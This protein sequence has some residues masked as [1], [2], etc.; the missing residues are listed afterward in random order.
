V[1]MLTAHM[2]SFEREKKLCT[3]ARVHTPLLSVFV[4]LWEPID[5]GSRMKRMVQNTW[6]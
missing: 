3:Y 5:M 1:C 2:V 4:Y 6:V